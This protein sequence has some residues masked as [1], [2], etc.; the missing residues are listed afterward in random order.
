[1][2]SSPPGQWPEKIIGKT[3]LILELGDLTKSHAQAVVNAAN[4]SL[5]GGAGVDGA[6]HREGGP[7][8]LKECRALAARIGRLQPG[9]AVIT[10]GGRLPAENV[11]HTVGPIWRGGDKRE[12]DILTS[13]YRESL[14]LAD[15]MALQSIAFPSIS[16]GAYAYPLVPAAELAL[17]TV[18]QYLEGETGLRSV[19]F[20]LFSREVFDVYQGVLGKL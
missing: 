4:P 14:T 7:A 12:A 8:I 5:L 2:T 10:T 20:V 15:D 6:I 3:R 18:K 11:I 9:R 17:Q 16:T 13:A 19:T 1:M